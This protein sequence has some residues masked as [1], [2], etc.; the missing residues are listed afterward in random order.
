M[1]KGRI[2]SIRLFMPLFPTSPRSSNG[3]H[4]ALES[5]RP[6]EKRRV[7]PAHFSAIHFAQQPSIHQVIEERTP[8]NVDVG[9]SS[10]DHDTYPVGL[11]FDAWC[12]ARRSAA[13]TEC[14]GRR[15]ERNSSVS[16]LVVRSRGARLRRRTARKEHPWG[17]AVPIRSVVFRRYTWCCR[18]VASASRSGSFNALGMP[19]GPPGQSSSRSCDSPGGWVTIAPRYRTTPAHLAMLP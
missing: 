11:V 9:L 13:K 10:C 3:H 7:S 15:S 8:L 19:R 2:L 18:R 16:L 4:T 6:A 17:D 14:R 12:R 5:K 1:A